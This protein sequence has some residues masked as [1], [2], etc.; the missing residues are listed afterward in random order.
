MG[1]PILIA[2][3]GSPRRNGNSA[4]LAQE[5][6]AGSKAAGAAVESYFLHGMDI[7]P[8]RACDACKEDTAKDCVVNDGMQELYPK[9]RQADAIVIASPIYWFTVS[10]QTKLVMDR[11]YALGGP[12][13]YALSGKRFGVILTYEDTD[14]FTSGAVNAL[15][16]FQD[17]FKFLGADMVG[18]VYGRAAGP[19]EV[20]KN[21][22]LMR[23]AYVLGERLVS[24]L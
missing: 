2:L 10:A 8:C 12:Q 6:V 19:G 23:S 17:A 1:K 16:T 22:E 4:A 24:G 13:G 11:W 9:L 7:H 20:R 3:L 21:K 5:A 18:A 15:R 14:P